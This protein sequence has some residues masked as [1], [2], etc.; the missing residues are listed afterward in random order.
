MVRTFSGCS[1]APLEDLLGEANLVRS[2]DKK[3][4]PKDTLGYPRDVNGVYAISGKNFESSS[5]KPVEFLGLEKHSIVKEVFSAHGEKIR[6]TTVDVS[7]KNDLDNKT[8]YPAGSLVSQDQG[9]MRTWSI[10]M[11]V[12]K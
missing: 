1:S 4:R 9:Q 6:D 12:Q 7:F 11:N 3:E 10:L 8:V 2:T 5:P